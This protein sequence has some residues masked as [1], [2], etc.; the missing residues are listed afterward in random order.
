LVGFVDQWGQPVLGLLE[1]VLLLVGVIVTIGHFTR[2]R[3]SSYIERFNSKD[4]LEC[5]SEVERWLRSHP[6]RRERLEAL[7]DDPALASQLKQFANLFQELGAA[8]RFKVAHRET[9]ET[10]FAELVIIYWEKLRFWVL[11]YRASAYPSLYN[12]FEW[13]YGEMKQVSPRPR[14][15]S[16]Y[17]VAYGSLMELESATRGLGRRVEADELLPATLEGYRRSWSIGEAVMVQGDPLQAV[18]LDVIPET[19]ASSQVLILKVTRDELDRLRRREKNY[20]STKVTRQVR[21]P[22][23][24]HLGPDA[25]A[26]CFTGKEDHRVE[27]GR[28]DAIL[29][30]GYVDKVCVGARAVTPELPEEIRRSA[31][32]SGWRRVPGD[33]YTFADSRQ[34]RLV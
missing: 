26:Y 6:T 29:L 12:G 22:G 15:L 4:M 27:A 18:F 33:H 1:I 11:D 24:R 14:Q 23:Q 30:E 21:L 28:D 7:D 10:L 16:M 8:Y 34:N 20:E 5:R 19:G 2:T 3:A 32:Q 13:L 17:V 9:V 31:E 25:I